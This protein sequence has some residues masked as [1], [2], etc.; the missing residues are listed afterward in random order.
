M[1]EMIG[2]EEVIRGGI[3]GEGD[4][5]VDPE[6]G[7]GEADQDQETE[8]IEGVEKLN[9]DPNLLKNHVRVDDDGK[10]YERYICNCCITFAPLQHSCRM[11]MSWDVPPRGFEHISPLQFKA[12]QG[13]IVLPHGRNTT[14][15][16][17]HPCHAPYL[18]RAHYSLE[19]LDH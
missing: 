19:N 16:T 11:S 15:S 14:L 8:K 4:R 18:E 2:G 5:E 7:G 12:M 1:E 6:K 10:Q 17:I 3:G 13:M 9:L